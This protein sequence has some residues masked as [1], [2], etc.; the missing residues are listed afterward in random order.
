[1]PRLQGKTSNLPATLLT[2]ILLLVIAFVVLE[3]V[4]VINVLP[5]FGK[6]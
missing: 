4:G 6:V 3:Y 2:V 5:N 1:M